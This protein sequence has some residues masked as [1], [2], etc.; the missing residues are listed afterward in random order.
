MLPREA[1][2]TPATH[3][4]ARPARRLAVRA[5][6]GK[7]VYDAHATRAGASSE[8]IASGEGAGL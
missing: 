4:P 6:Q 1:L 7:R 2:F 8:R 3:V 5:I